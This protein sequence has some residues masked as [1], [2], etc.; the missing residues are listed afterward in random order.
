[1]NQQE[2]EDLIQD[3]VYRVVTGGNLVVL[4]EG[5]RQ[6]AERAIEAGRRYAGPHCECCGSF[7]PYFDLY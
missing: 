2:L 5:V 4:P 7:S 1:M 6:A 3:V